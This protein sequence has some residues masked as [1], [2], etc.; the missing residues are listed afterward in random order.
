MFS[1]YIK[2]LQ[3]L[4]LFEGMSTSNILAVLSHLPV[5]LHTYKKNEFI[6]LQNETF[7]K[8]GILLEGKIRTT[9]TYMA[10]STF[11]LNTFYGPCI[12]GENIICAECKAMP[13]SLVT[14]QPAVVFLIDGDSIL[15][16]TKE[17]SPFM[18]RFLINMVRVMAKRSI[19]TSTQVEYS[20]IASLKKRIAIFLLTKSAETKKLLFTIP[21]NRSEMA[22]Y[23]CVTRP[24]LS[25]ALA[26][27]KKENII[28]YYRDSF[29]IQDLEKL[30]SL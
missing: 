24:A 19:L 7:Y 25:K 16:M 8:L 1:P 22:N 30:Q 23:L 6:C 21:L 3:Q 4:E 27:L 13:Y 26:E 29:K 20:H 18:S 17:T 5:S 10:G 14:L 15:T 9:K 2:Q 11:S 28:D 12:F